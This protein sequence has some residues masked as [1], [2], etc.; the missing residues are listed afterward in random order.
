MSNTADL[1]CG[2]L[3]RLEI[4]VDIDKSLKKLWLER[5]PGRPFI[6]A[7]IKFLPFKN[8]SLDELISVHSIEHFSHREVPLILK[9][10]CRVLKRGAK[11]TI[12]CPN[13]VQICK[14]MVFHG[15]DNGK[16]GYEVCFRLYGGQDS[17]YNFHKSGFNYGYLAALLREA[18]FPHVQRKIIKE[19]GPFYD[20][21]NLVVEAWKG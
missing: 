5:F 8:E 16:E 12:S 11:L 14:N 19:I 4:G 17:P 15:D 21:D 7:D 3:P 6:I 9:E 13:I 10:W 18:G 1:G 2:A 20:P